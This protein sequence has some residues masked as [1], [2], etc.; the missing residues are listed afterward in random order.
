MV[1]AVLLLHLLRLQAILQWMLASVL[2]LHLLQALQ[3]V[4]LLSLSATL[5]VFVQAILQR[6]L[7]LVVVHSYLLIFKDEKYSLKIFKYPGSI[8][9]CLHGLFT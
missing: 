9:V 6:M 4:V 8:K 3:T 5:P 1:A 2:L 7:I